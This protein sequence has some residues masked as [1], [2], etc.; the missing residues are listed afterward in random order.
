[1]KTIGE[2]VGASLIDL[3]EGQDELK[4]ILETRLAN[5]DAGTN[6][7]LAQIKDLLVESLE[8]H[9]ALDQDFKK[10]R[11]T[12]NEQIRDLRKERKPNG[13]LPPPVPAE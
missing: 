13:I 6:V 3:A 11:D 1:M 12:T 7:L 10:F 4:D 9:N 5:R 2:K 8:K